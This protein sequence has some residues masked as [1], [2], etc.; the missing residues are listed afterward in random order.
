MI[1]KKL[2]QKISRVLFFV[3]M[4]AILALIGLALIV[5]SLADNKSPSGM[6]GF[7]LIF[8]AGMAYLTWFKSRN[9]RI[10]VD[11]EYLLLHQQRKPLFVKY[12]NIS[13]AIRTKDN[14]LVL[15]VREG[16]EIKKI[17]VWLKELE[18]AD[19]EKFA[20]FCQKKGWK[21]R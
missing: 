11:D 2:Y 21:N 20:D 6:E 9:P 3:M 1:G 12:K 4:Y 19:A 5:S 14:R 13:S 8:G 18:D 17:T 15:D 7:T 16:H 10:I